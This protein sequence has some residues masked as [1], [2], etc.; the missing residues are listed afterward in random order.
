V[1]GREKKK[2]RGRASKGEK[3]EESSGRRHLCDVWWDMHRQSPM[4]RSNWKYSGGKNGMGAMGG[5][6]DQGEGTMAF[7]QNMG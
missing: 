4:F 3:S 7:S 2:G 5:G 1:V 6:D